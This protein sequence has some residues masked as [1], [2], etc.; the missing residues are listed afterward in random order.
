MKRGTGAGRGKDGSWGG[1]NWGAGRGRLRGREGRWGAGRGTGDWGA[2][3]GAGAVGGLGEGW[4][5]YGDRKLRGKFQVT[6]LKLVW[7]H[8]EASAFPDKNRKAGFDRQ[9]ITAQR[10]FKLHWRVSKTI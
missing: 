3:R 9:R 2:G 7:L 5:A 8:F 10:F 4:A 1:G 6:T